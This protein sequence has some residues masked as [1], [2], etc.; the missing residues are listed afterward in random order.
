M[1]NLN[2]LAKFSSIMITCRDL[3]D[4]YRPTVCKAHKTR[5]RN[6]TP[7]NFLILIPTH[8]LSGISPYH[9][10]LLYLDLVSIICSHPIVSP[11]LVRRCSAIAQAIVRIPQPV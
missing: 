10:F 8:L 6:R 9:R 3:K 5:Y 11:G 1:R 2:A 4:I 7:L